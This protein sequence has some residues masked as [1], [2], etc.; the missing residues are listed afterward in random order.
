MSSRKRAQLQQ[1]VEIEVRRFIAGAILFNLKAAE[2]VGI[3]AT[4]MQCLHVLALEG[5]A[6]PTQ[7]AGWSRLTTGGI[8][9]VLDRLER[10]GY[11]KR[12]PNPDDRRSIIVRPVLSAFSKFESIY[13]SKAKA[14]AD[15]L[16]A[17]N[18]SEL[19]VILDFFARTNQASRD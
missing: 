2:D 5:S 7:L 16:D 13:R 19:R 3:N 11:L 4:D 8:T 6:T 10:A 18:D 9:V 15:A 12:E 14:L 1:T 17:F